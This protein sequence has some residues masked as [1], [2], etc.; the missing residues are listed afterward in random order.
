MNYFFKILRFGIPY[1]RFAFLN[2]FFNVL[3][4]IFSALAYVSMIPMM[5]ILF[6][7]TPKTTVPP[8][9]QGIGQIKNYLEGF[10]NYKITQYMD[11]DSG[12]ALIFVI[13]III[14]LFFLKN[15]FNYLAM[16]FITFLRNGVLKDLRNELYQKTTTL[17]LYFFSEKKK[18]DLMAR[19][20]SDVLELQHSFLSILELIVRDPLTIIFSLIVMFS[21]SVKLT[22]FVLIFIPV[23]GGIISQIGKS[24][25]R[26]SDSVQ[27]EQG[28]FLSLLEETL[29]GIKIIKAFSAENT[30]VKKFK[31]S[32]GRFF[33]FSNKLLNRQNLASPVSEFL[34]IVV[35]SILLWYGG[36]MVLI[37]QTLNGAIFLSYLGLA[38]NILTP[39]K[40][41]SKAYYSV[42]KGDAAAL[43]IMEILEAQ[44]DMEDVKDA[45]DIK[46]LEKEIIFD[47]VSF[48]YD[49]TPVLEDFSLK[50]E[51]G[52]TVA[53]VGPSG[54]GK[55]TLANLLNRFYDIDKGS[56][57]LD[58][59]PID[60]VKKKSLYGLTGMVTQDSILFNDSVRNNIALGNPKA[61]LE[62][63]KEAAK[64]ANATE[65]IE[66]LEKGYDS[67]IGEGGNKLSG[68]QKQ[69]LSIARAILKDPDILILDEATSALDTGSEKMVQEALE[70]LM[71]NRTSL[72]IAHRLSTIQKADL[73][74][75][76]NH[77]KVVETGTHSELLAKKAVYKNLVELQTL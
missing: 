63:I 52:Q 33:D 67:I 47:K 10:F 66:K 17:P 43:R 5:Q 2:I 28:E 54:S 3:Y 7:T 15:I 72:V 23:S 55:T 12:K 75:V 38:Y 18:G 60:V 64:I 22:L 30:F 11:Q 48:S 31:Q 20:S 24:L 42:K 59:T 73:I 58:G 32:T 26:K 36:K 16:F 25:K 8:T 19:I 61:T 56:L 44:D 45:V 70:N 62:Q 65:F 49:Q 68:G 35:I 29:G 77:G 9:Y 57:T 1:K 27:K 74:V 14:S 41:I 53:L 46:S 13:G 4:A 71:K 69:R 37:D 39:A 21:F 34:G 50:I 51:K 40:G 76:L 6:G